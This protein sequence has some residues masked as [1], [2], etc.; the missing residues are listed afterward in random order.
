MKKLGA[1]ALLGVVVLSGCAMGM[2]PITGFIYMDVAGPLTATGAT[3]GFVKIGQSA[4]TS[5]LG[6]VGTGDASI[7]AAAASAGITKI[8]HVDYHTVNYVGV[9]AKTTV[10]VYGE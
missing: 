5:I 9:W 2:S 7:N 4:A 1:V 3:S 6:I 10:T 8:H